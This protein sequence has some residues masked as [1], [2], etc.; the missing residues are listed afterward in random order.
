MRTALFCSVVLLD[1]TA[2][3]TSLGSLPSS[4]SSS[5][6]SSSLSF[7]GSFSSSSSSAAAAAAKWSSSSRRRPYSQLSRRFGE[8]EDELNAA[9]EKQRQERA[10]R[11][12]EAEEEKQMEASGIAP[13]EPTED[14]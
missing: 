8:L 6:S 11:D 12:R 14:E 1:S 4:S 13:E 3:W 10:K 9:F 2:A 5:S 7:H